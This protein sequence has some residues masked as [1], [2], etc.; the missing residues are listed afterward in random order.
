M[1]GDGNGRRWFVRRL[2]RWGRSNRRR[3]PWREERDPFRILIA[4]M[5]LQRSRGTTVAGVYEEVF[6][7]WPTSEALARADEG[8]IA[9]VIA[10]LGLTRRAVALKRMAAQVVSDGMP[11]SVEDLVRLSGV[12]RYSAS[13]TASAAYGRREPTVDGTSARVYRRF[14][15]LIAD[16][17]SHVDEDLW[18]LVDQV[19]PG[20]GAIRE[21]NWAVLDLASLICLPRLPRCPECPLVAKCFVGSQRILSRPEVKITKM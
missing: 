9:E 13:A 20:R 21:W 6:R 12:G 19:T 14:F 3:F 15:G 2:L 1:D 16:R 11:R 18:A 10:P 17:D 7:R 8:E 4:E 5:L